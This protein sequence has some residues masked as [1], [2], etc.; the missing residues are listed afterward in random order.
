MPSRSTRP[1]DPPSHPGRRATD[2]QMSRWPEDA[3]RR[4]RDELFER[5]LPLARRLARRYVS[6]HEPFE[7]LVQVASV[8]LLAAI[9][10]FDPERGIPFQSF[11]IPTILGELKRHFRNTGWAVHVPRSAQELALRID[12]AV[13][14]IETKLGRHPGVQEVAEY[15]EVSAEDVLAGLDAGTAHYAMSLDAPVATADAE[16]GAAVI[17]TI[18]HTDGGYGLSEM[19]LSL[20]VAVGRLPYLERAALSRRLEGERTQTEIGRE[21]GCSQMQVSRLLGRAAA[22]LREMTDPDLG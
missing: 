12:Q 19:K 7:D 2:D 14:E 15:L 17:D 16:D 18:G 8:G 22:H 11:A 20:A 10:R 6:S 4:A 5:F 3:D 9:D 1:V 21:L 13:R